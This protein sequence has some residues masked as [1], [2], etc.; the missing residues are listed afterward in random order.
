M[1]NDKNII[2][3]ELLRLIKCD[4]SKAL[5]I[6]FERYY[7]TLC[8][9]SFRYVK[10]VD[11]TEE[12]VSDVFLNIWLKRKHIEIKTNLKAYLYSA[13]RN[14]SINYL[15]RKNIPHENIEIAD[16]ENVISDSYAD[17]LVTHK[18]LKDDI[19]ALLRQIPEKR[20]IIFILSRIDGLSYKEIA[21]TLSISAN[22]VQN[23]M[24]E[25]IKFLS[26]KSPKY[27]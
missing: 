22:T 13:V 5:R 8:R 26:K 20:R 21:E 18:E 23:Q 14:Q 19:N 9:F 17:G 27:I 7:S 2:D 25:A 12:A 4:D 15:K 10:V 24:V 16:K 3:E 11:H 1:Q 6:L